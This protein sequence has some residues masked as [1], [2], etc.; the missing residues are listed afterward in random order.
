MERAG[1]SAGRI[2]RI[3]GE[4]WLGVLADVWGG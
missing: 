1:W 3:A 4:N 2:E